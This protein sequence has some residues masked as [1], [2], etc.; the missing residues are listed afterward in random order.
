MLVDCAVR[1]LS[2]AAT[3]LA[4]L[5]SAAVDA[6]LA[7]PVEPLLTLFSRLVVLLDTELMSLP[8]WLTLD[9]RPSTA[10]ETAP[11]AV[12]LTCPLSRQPVGREPYS[13]CGLATSKV[14]AALLPLAAWAR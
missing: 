4:T 6:L 7:N 1:P 5:V 12:L 11:M 10:V 8:C 2:V 13:T 3:R 9:V 14:P